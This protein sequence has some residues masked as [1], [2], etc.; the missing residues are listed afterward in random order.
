M[1]RAHAP[2]AEHVSQGRCEQF[3]STRL[4]SALVPADVLL[5]AAG[6]HDRIDW[7]T[8]RRLPV[9]RVRHTVH[10]NDVG[11]RRLRRVYVALPWNGALHCHGRQRF[12][13][14]DALFHLNREKLSLFII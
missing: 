3:L 12:F 10:S 14:L 8:E 13:L 1:A 6:V 9:G 5:A 2:M 7:R 11:P 4:P